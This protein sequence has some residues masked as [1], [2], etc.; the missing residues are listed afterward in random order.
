[1]S[2]CVDH[3]KMLSRLYHVRKLAIGRQCCQ[4]SPRKINALGVSITEKISKI[5]ELKNG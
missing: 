4:L 2:H 5:V 1:M 3:M